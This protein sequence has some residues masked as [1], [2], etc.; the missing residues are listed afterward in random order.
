MCSAPS[1]PS[2]GT[3]AI[4]GAGSAGLT[5][6]KGLRDAGVPAVCFERGSRVGGNWVFDNDNQQS[7]IYRSLR[8][9]TSRDRMQF[10]DFPM[11]ADYPD[12]ASHE[13]VARYFEAYAAHFELGQSIRFRSHVTRVAPSV[14]GGYTVETATGAERFDAVIVANGHHWDP[15]YPDPAV[16]GSFH[17]VTFHAH[18]YVDPTQPH[19]LG[20]KRVV[21]VGIGNSAV[22]IASELA[23]AGARVTLSVRRGAWVLP[24]YAFGKPIDQPGIIPERFS[25]TLKTSLAELWYRARIGPPGAYGL[26]TP[27]HRLGHA[28]PTLSDELLP[29]LRDGK[30][31]AR[32]ALAELLDDSVRFADGSR[33]RVDAIVYCTGYKVSFPFFDPSFVS[34]PNNE[35][36]LFLRCFHLEHPNLMFAGLCQPLGAVMPL[37]EAQGRLFARFLSG[38]YQL[39]DPTEMRRRT[40]LEREHVRR[41]F[42]ATRR[43]T[44][45]VDFD[46]YLDDLARELRAGTHRHGN[47]G[48]AVRTS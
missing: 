1:A 11:P 37:V 15:A 13:Q 36:P 22:D 46:R 35:L 45:Q 27:D 21:V 8:I 9:N 2:A 38:E 41:R 34:A 33:E 16:P 40:Q 26:P 25:D 29:L 24:R 23:K 14:A 32:P 10:A 7:R 12:Y 18:D 43:H 30:I 19:E 20:G 6:L 5:V 17:G 31:V 42:V 3:A 4:I 48:P 39:P 47:R 28:H 44:M